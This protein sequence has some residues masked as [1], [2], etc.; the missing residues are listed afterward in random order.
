MAMKMTQKNTSATE[1]RLLT[2]RD[3]AELDQVSQKT[4]RRAIEQGR[5]SVVRIGPS[6]HLIR[7]HPS[8]HAA[9]R[10]AVAK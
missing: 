4:V 3:V 8:A 2:I 6:G 9:Y 7:I 10:L 5:L 1:V